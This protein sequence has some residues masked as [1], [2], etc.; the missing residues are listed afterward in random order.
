MTVFAVWPQLNV[1][2][3]GALVLSSG[4]PGL[5]F[6]V[7]SPKPDGEAWVGYDVEKEH[8]RLAP[9]DPFDSGTTPSYTR[10]AGIHGSTTSYTG[11]AEAEPGVVLLAYDKTGAVGDIQRVYSMRIDVRAKFDDA[12]CTSTPRR[13]TALWR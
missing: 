7:S 3:N 9:T 13:R 4:R 12:D 1:L 10:Q 5:G 11:L 2:S 8:D 6:W